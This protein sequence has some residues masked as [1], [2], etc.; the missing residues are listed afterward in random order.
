MDLVDHQVQQASAPVPPPDTSG[1]VVFPKAAARIPMVWGG[2]GIGWVRVGVTQLML[3]DALSPETAYQTHLHEVEAAM[4][5]RVTKARPDY[6]ALQG[7]HE[8]AMGSA[9]MAQ[10]AATEQAAGGAAA[11][12]EVQ[13]PDDAL[14]SFAR[15]PIE[16]AGGTVAGTPLA[17][18]VPADG[19]VESK[20][21]VHGAFAGPDQ[22]TGEGAATYLRMWLRAR[23]R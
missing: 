11:A 17:D 7:H 12:A 15:L 3:G 1:A 19:S 16:V 9:H 13:V 14:L 4:Q 20:P 22:F 21:H 8:A 10:A 6:A 23:W 5:A 2:P 18:M